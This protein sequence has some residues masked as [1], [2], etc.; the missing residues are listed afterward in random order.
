MDM[1]I[2]SAAKLIIIYTVLV[3]C[4]ELGR[5]SNVLNTRVIACLLKLVIIIR[6]PPRV[7]VDICLSGDDKI[8]V[9]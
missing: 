5:Q 6:F 4:L 2:G 3:Q 9:E 8:I 1:Q 7:V